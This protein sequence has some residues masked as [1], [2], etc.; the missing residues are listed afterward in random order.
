M[1]GDILISFLTQVFFT[2][3][4]IVIFGLLIALCNKLFYTNVGYLG[5]IAC[6]V[7]GCVGTPVHEC[8]HALCCLIFGHKIVSM[9][10]FQ[11]S[12]TDGTLGYVEHTYNPKNIYQRIGNFFIGVAPILVTSA[13][14]YLLSYLLVPNML[15][16]MIT[17]T[18]GIEVSIGEIFGS[19]FSAIGVF[20][21]YA[22]T[23]NWWIFLLI[24]MFLALHMT[25]SPADIKN[26]LSGLIVLLAVL[27]IADV[28]L[29]L[30][31]SYLL[32]SVTVWFVNVGSVLSSFLILALIISL[33]AVIISFGIKLAFKKRAMQ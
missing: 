19:I 7:T 17:Q 31:D 28:V 29:G 2:V 16:L 14:L 22:R 21:T 1:I 27:L 26:A 23:L 3:G 25:L 33:V 12:S 9:K 4:I 32:L 30:I 11:I 6:Y 8:A 20:F 13:L 24:G 10:L 15:E 18:V 5:K